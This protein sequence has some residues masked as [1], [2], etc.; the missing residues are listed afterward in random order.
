MAEVYGGHD[1][2]GGYCNTT[3]SNSKMTHSQWLFRNVHVH[4]FV[5]GGIATKKKEE[6]IGRELENLIEFGGEGLEEKDLYLLKIN[7]D[8]LETTSGELHTYW[9]LA[10]CAARAAKQPREEINSIGVESEEED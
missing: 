2:K 6:M 7:L 10:L 5:S 8:D 4:D 1:I 9:L 3:Q